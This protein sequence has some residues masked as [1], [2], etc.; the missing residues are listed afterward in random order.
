MSRIP[1]AHVG[2][3]RAKGT[4]DFLYCAKAHTLVAGA[5]TKSV[6]LGEGK[7]E[8]DALCRGD[9]NEAVVGVEVGAESFP[10]P[11]GTELGTSCLS[12]IALLGVFRR[13]SDQTAEVTCSLGI[14]TRQGRDWG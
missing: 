6:L 5:L 7:D 1:L 8:V 9:I 13:T 2:E 3:R 14:K 12:N 10:M 11:E 4:E